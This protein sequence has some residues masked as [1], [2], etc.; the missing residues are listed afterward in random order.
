MYWL[1]HLILLMTLR[2]RH[3]TAVMLHARVAKAQTE[4]FIWSDTEL[5]MWAEWLQSWP[6]CTVAPISHEWKS[7]CI[8]RMLRSTHCKI[9]HPRNKL[10]NCWAISSTLHPHHWHSRCSKCQWK[11]YIYNLVSF[12]KKC[13]LRKM[14]NIFYI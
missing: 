12:Q 11:K 8:I 7:Y 3:A 4:K 10:K 13:S 14:E 1:P 9:S 2:S 6:L 5:R